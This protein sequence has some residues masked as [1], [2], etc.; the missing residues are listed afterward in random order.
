MRAKKSL[1][2]NFLTSHAIARDIVASA[3]ITDDDTVLEIGPGKGFLTEHLLEKAGRVVSVEKDDR[4]IKYLKDKFA[5]EIRD[6]KLEL[7]NKDILLFNSSDYK[8]LTTN[9]KLVANIPYYITGEILRFFL[10]GD[11]QPSCMVLMVQKEI[12]ERIVARDNKES[13]LSMS[14]KAYGA[15]R[16][17]QKVSA[18]YFSPVPNVDSAI[19]L[20]ENIS[21]KNFAVAEE[22][23]KF[24]EILKRGFAHKRKMLLGNLK[25]FYDAQKLT[26]GFEKCNIEPT[27]RAEKLS[28]SNWWC[29]RKNIKEI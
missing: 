12:A 28:F 29:L 14:V 24:F 18:R 3:K 8:L 26:E 21:K 10:S 4:M 13:I 7:V 16:Y 9:Y 6:G 15:P 27:A 23:K 22:E 17:I 20:I 19:L 1:G 25:K 2:Q 5:K 11:V